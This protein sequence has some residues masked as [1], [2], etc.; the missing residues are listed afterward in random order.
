MRTERRRRKRERRSHKKGMAEPERLSERN[1]KE[2][3][4]RHTK[5]LN[6]PACRTEHLVRSYASHGWFGKEES[7]HSL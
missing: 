1:R 3:K 5:T 7:K 6:V 4:R 2:N